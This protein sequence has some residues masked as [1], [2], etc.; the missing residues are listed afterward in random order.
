M[1]CPIDSA[2]A[3]RCDHRYRP[4]SNFATTRSNQYP[5]EGKCQLL[6]AASGQS[7]QEAS[8]SIHCDAGEIVLRV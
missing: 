8:D 3:F 6:S 4:S 1:R 5:P 7:S 2:S